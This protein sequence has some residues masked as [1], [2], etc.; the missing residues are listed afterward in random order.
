MN[1]YNDKMNN[2]LGKST[3]IRITFLLI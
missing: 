2:D 3:G 1:E